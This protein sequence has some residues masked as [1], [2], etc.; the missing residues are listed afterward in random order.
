MSLP[1][2]SSVPDFGRRRFIKN[3]SS[4]VGFALAAPAV[5]AQSA[6]RSPSTMTPPPPP[7]M[8]ELTLRINGTEKKLCVDSRTTLL[9]A[10]RERLTL[11]GT[12]KGCDRGEC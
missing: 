10:L 3:T 8:M 2:S 1:H 7:E 5:L 6:A 12:K 4:V 11:T 9:D